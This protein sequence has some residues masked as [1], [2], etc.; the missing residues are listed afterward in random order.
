[1]P[2]A[3]PKATTYSDA[4]REFLALY[5]NRIQPILRPAG[6]KTWVSVSKHWPLSD[7]QI[8]KAVDK[9][10]GEAVWGCRWGEQ[11]RFA[12]FDI[13]RDSKYHNVQELQKLAQLLADVGLDV[14]PYQSSSSGG[15]HLY[16]FFDDWHSCSEVQLSLKAWLIAHGYA[17]RNGILEVFPSGNGLRFP[18]QQGFAWLAPDGALRVQRDE[19]STDQALSRFLRDLATRAS[20]WQTCKNLIDSQ[21]QVAMQP[22]G[23]AGDEHQ[24]AIDTEG[25]DGLWSYR[26]IPE[27]YE[28]GRRYWQT[29]LTANGQR[30]EAMLSI[31]HY[32]WHGDE[33]LGVPALPG[34]WNDE[35]RFRLIRAWLA[36]KHNGFCS[37][38]NRGNWQKVEA[39]IR[40]SVKWR[41]P[42][43]GLRIIQPYPMT[44]R[45]IETLMD[46]SRATGRT[47]TTDD[48]KK[49]NDGREEKT[50]AKIS[51][52]LKTLIQEGGWI[53]R[54]ELARVSGCSPNS[55]SKHRDLWLLLTSGS[56][57]QSPFLD[58]DLLVLDQITDTTYGVPESG[59]AEEENFLSSAFLG[60][61]RQTEL[62]GQDPDSDGFAPIVVGPPL[63]LPGVKP[64]SELPASSP[65][66]SDCFARLDV[67][68]WVRRYSGRGAGDADG[69]QTEREHW[70]S[71]NQSFRG[72]QDSES[73]R[74]CAEGLQVKSQWRRA[75]VVRSAHLLLVRPGVEFGRASFILPYFVR[76]AEWLLLPFV[77]WPRATASRTEN[78]ARGV[79]TRG[80]SSSCVVRSVR[81]LRQFKTRAPPR[82]NA[83]R[84]YA[85][86]FDRPCMV[87]S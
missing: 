77:A 28:A 39:D 50:R 66:P 49:G 2:V 13:D 53:G 85:I 86:R 54:N 59:C 41:R 1:M 19:L 60:D 76:S 8:L 48:L 37:R 64:T 46:R 6:C 27:R 7:E 21:L 17:I 11:T 82:Q 16:L 22:A 23:G 25:F 67:G 70:R 68:S 15:W 65:S 63:L 73:A 44:E 4:R 32:F 9:A 33:S 26:L 87:G 35:A 12:V 36:E 18:L 29:G 83:M 30:H 75:L 24:N 55:V 20:D 84:M 45:A 79:A 81:K 47:W 51:A 31:E 40:R 43:N 10:D 80:C 61:S 42:S 62:P 52:A 72:Q 71:K 69:S 38:I 57:D 34:E 56:G 58:R 14:A 78:A 3:S 5:P 74:G